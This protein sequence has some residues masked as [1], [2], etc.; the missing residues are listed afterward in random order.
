MSKASI[1]SCVSGRGYEA[2]CLNQ[3]HLPVVEDS[4]SAR[5]AG[6]VLT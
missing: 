1:V 5:R 2:S 3:V 4:E 6:A